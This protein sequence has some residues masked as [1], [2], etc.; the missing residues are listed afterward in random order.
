MLSGGGAIGR[1]CRIGAGAFSKHVDAEDCESEDG[2]LLRLSFSLALQKWRLR[3]LK[4]MIRLSSFKLVV[5][6]SEDI[7]ANSCPQKFGYI[8]S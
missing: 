2:Q 1:C 7:S 6:A 4:L 5:H 8:F 3:S